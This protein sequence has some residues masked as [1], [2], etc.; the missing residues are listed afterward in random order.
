MRRVG[1]AV[2]AAGVLGLGLAGCGDGGGGADRPA[3]KAS[4]KASA[5]GTGGAGGGGLGADGYQPD[6]PPP[7]VSD[8]PDSPSGDIDRKATAEGWTYDELY[9]SASAFVDDVCASLPESA[10]ASSSRPQWLVESGMLE[11]D[12]KAILTFGV[13]KLCPEWKAALAQAV[14]GRFERW[15]TDGDWEVSADPAPSG[16]AGGSD[17]QRAAP[18]TYRIT[19]NLADCYWERT[20]RSGGIIANQMASQARMLTVTLRAG[21]LFRSQGCDGVWKPVR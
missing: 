14:S 5:G 4:G 8:G 15:L 6:S 21:E 12:G 10:V 11:G 13:P 2:V 7:H 18:G 16:A 1:A 9:D 19:G 3:A 20:S 17:V